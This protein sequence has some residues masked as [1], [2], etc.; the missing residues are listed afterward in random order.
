MIE[1]KNKIQEVVLWNNQFRLK[2]NVNNSFFPYQPF[3]VVVVVTSLKKC[4][5]FYEI[6]YRLNVYIERDR[7]IGGIRSRCE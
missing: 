5:F 1:E 7:K 3:V 2:F 6:I 4:M